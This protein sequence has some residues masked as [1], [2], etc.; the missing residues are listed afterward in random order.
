M[1]LNKVKTWNYCFGIN[2]VSQ[3]VYIRTTDW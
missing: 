2:D 3:I 1:H